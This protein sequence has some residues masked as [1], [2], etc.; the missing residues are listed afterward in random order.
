MLRVVPW[1]E[2]LCNIID[3][4]RSK[5]LGFYVLELI[6]NKIKFK[7]DKNIPSAKLHQ[8]N[9]TIND[10]SKIFQTYFLKKMSQSQEDCRSEFWCRQNKLPTWNNLT[11]S[12]WKENVLFVTIIQKILTIYSYNVLWLKISRLL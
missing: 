2:F 6:F 7:L 4:P 10:D 8:K 1:L 11:K 12:R 3:S 5:N 9:M